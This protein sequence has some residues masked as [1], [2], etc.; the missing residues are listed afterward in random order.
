MGGTKEKTLP[1]LIKQGLE[2]YN[3]G[4]KWYKEYKRLVYGKDIEEI[5]L[6]TE[7]LYEKYERPRE[8]CSSL[9]FFDG[10]TIGKFLGDRANDWYNSLSPEEKYKWENGGRWLHHGA[11]GE[12][13]QI[14]G[15]HMGNYFVRGL[16]DG[17]MKSDE[18]DRPKWHDR[19]YFIALAIV[20]EMNRNTRPGS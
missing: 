11:I 6:W 15:K 8:Q 3:E 1:N 20:E 12:L 5:I 13:L 14:R 7:R 10:C 17:L 16:G 19:N 2:W 18:P 4:L 9:E